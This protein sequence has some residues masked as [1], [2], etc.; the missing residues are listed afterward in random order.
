MEG[1]STKLHNIFHTEHSEVIQHND[2]Y[3][4]SPLEYNV[5][6]TM[7]NINVVL[8]G[9]RGTPDQAYD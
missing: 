5:S 7:S 1:M 4:S 3:C 8:S 9:K 2:V 6:C